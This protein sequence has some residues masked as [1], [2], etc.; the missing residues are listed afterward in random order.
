MLVRTLRICFIFGFQRKI[1]SFIV[2]P[3]YICILIESSQE[4]GADAL[5]I[6][7]LLV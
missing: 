2:F 5:N 3:S 4:A 6:Y 7:G 1:S